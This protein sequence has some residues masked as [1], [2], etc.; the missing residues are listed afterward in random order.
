MIEILSPHWANLI[1]KNLEGDIMPYV[2]LNI[3]ATE[4]FIDNVQGKASDSL[5]RCVKAC[6]DGTLYRNTK[7]YEDL[8]QL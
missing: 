2:V 5:R 6:R 4:C 7:E 8:I 3:L 1:E